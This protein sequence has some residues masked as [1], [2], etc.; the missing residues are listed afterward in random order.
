MTLLCEMI[1]FAAQRLMELE[2]EPLCGAGHGARARAAGM[3]K[4]PHGLRKAAASRVAEGKPNQGKS[5][6]G[7][8]TLSEVQ[9]YTEAVRPEHMARTT[10]RWGCYVANPSRRFA[11]I[12]QFH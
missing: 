11:E 4:S 6:T 12:R 2:T 10:V 9:R 1:G 8:R 5:L 3:S 7:H